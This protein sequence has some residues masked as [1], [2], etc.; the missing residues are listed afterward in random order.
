M[1][2][3]K[4]TREQVLVL[5]TLPEKQEF[6]TKENIEK[7]ASDWAQQGRLQKIVAHMRGESRYGP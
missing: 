5:S 4:R 1:H 7:V 2:G 3:H 6:F